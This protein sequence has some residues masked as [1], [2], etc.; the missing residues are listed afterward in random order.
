MRILIKYPTRGRPQAFLSRL[1][2]WVSL[3][4]NPD[5]L[6]FL[7]SYDS[8]DAT[9]TPDVMADAERMHPS[10]ICVRGNSKSKIEACNADIAEYEADWDIILLASDDMF[11]RRKGW[12]EMVRLHMKENFPD[13]DGCLWFHDGTK[14]RVI[15][16]LSVVGRLYYQ[17]FGCLYEKSYLSFFCDNEFTEVAQSL[18][19]IVF[20][21]HPIATHE[22]PAWNGG[23]KRDETYVRNN[24]H[25]AQDEKNYFNRKSLGFPS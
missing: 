10:I 7:V 20:I 1:K 11:C 9:M 18:G 17:R 22:H 8:D 15:C 6:S 4:S 21:E 25:W 2:E 5:K 14:Q 19:R 13:L 12:D 16:T 23:M 3:A 24:K